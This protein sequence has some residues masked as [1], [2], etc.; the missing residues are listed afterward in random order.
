MEGY[1]LLQSMSLLFLKGLQSNSDNS[2]S[3]DLPK[4][5]LLYTFESQKL[6]NITSKFYGIKHNL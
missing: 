5:I 6:L 4:Y 2:K 1:Q 3:I